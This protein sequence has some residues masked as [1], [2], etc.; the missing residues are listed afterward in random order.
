MLYTLTLY[1]A[2]KTWFSPP[3]LFFLIY[4]GSLLKYFAATQ[5]KKY[6]QPHK[7]KRGLPVRFPHLQS[8]KIKIKYDGRKFRFPYCFQKSENHM[9]H[10][11][12][13][14]H[15]SDGKGHIKGT[16]T[17]NWEFRNSLKT[18]ILIVKQTMWICFECPVWPSSSGLRPRLQLQSAVFEISH[19]ASINE[20]S[21][22]YFDDFKKQ[23]QNNFSV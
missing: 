11:T 21:M 3:F 16:S 5:K 15:F 4:I 8:W 17:S 18:Y 19:L 20:N 10:C 13:N 1:F 6:R 7:F 12:A 14:E 9:F 23:F 22:W 2:Y